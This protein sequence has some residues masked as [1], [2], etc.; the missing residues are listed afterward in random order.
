MQYHC[1]VTASEKSKAIKSDLAF[2]TV[3]MPPKVVRMTQNIKNDVS[4]VKIALKVNSTIECVSED[5]NPQVTFD[6]YLGS[7]HSI[8]L[9]SVIFKG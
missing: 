8:K 6:W 4:A 9:L 2:L 3:L 7:V 1:Q 5:S